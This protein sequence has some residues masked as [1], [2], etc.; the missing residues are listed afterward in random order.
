[1]EKFAFFKFLNRLKN[2]NIKIEMLT[3]DRHFRH[4]KAHAGGRKKYRCLAFLQKYKVKVEH[5][6]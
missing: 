3:M 4:Q 2:E 1:M 5:S 6:F